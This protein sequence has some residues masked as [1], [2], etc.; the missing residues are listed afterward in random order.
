MAPE[1]PLWGTESDTPVKLLWGPE[2]PLWAPERPL[3]APERP[4]WAPE[5]PLWAPERLLWAPIMLLWAPERDTPVKLLWAP[6]RLLW[7]PMRP[8]WAPKNPAG[9]STPSAI[10]RALSCLARSPQSSIGNS[11]KSINAFDCARADVLARNSAPGG[12]SAPWFSVGGAGGHTHPPQ[13]PMPPPTASVLPEPLL[14]LRS[15]QFNFKAA[16]AATAGHIQAATAATGTQAATVA[17]T[18]TGTTQAATGTTQAAT[19]SPHRRL[20]RL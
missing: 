7:A 9:G 5:R 10:S 16:T 15:R 2:R 1:I 20:W 14:E 11:D 19:G 18:C 6:E 3:W 12:S 4:L 17:A 13:P 8:P